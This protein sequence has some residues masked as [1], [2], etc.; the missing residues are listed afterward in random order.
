MMQSSFKKMFS[1]AVFHN[2]F[3]NNKCNCLQFS[4]A[5]GC[6]TLMLKS[7]LLIKISSNGFELFSNTTGSTHTLLE[8][9]QKTS[10]IDYFEFDINTDNPY[11]ILFTEIPIN[12]LGQI[13]YSSRDSENQHQNGNIQLHEVLKEER[14]SSIGNL[15]IYFEDIRNDKDNSDDTNFEINFRA[16]ATQWQYYIITKNTSQFGNLTIKEKENITFE[17]PEQVVLETGE[18]AL[19]FSSGVTLIPL[20]EKPKY[21]FDLISNTTTNESNQKTAAHK[22]VFKGLP[23]PN[24]TQIGK[25][26]DQ[27]SSPMYV[28]L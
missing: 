25:N 10:G 7:G 20:S 28:Y 9:I 4:P 8:Y 12:W 19:L 5:N 15:R 2:Y 17:G 18:Q 27:I 26:K 16:R 24:V 6:K 22:I 14:T 13:T 1:V 23:F 21:R 11:F 3:E